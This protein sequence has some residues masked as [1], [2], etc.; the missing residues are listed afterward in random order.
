MNELLYYT[1]ADR[2]AASAELAKRRWL[3]YVPAALLL[4]LSVASFI[5]FRLHRNESG[6]P[7]TALLTMLGGAY[8]LFFQEVYLLPA[9]RYH[10]HVNY[11]LGNFLREAEGAIVSL[12]AEAKDN[13]GLDCHAMILNIGHDN[14]PN[15]E[16]LFYIDALKGLPEVTQGMRVRVLSNNRMIA[17]LEPAPKEN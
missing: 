3:V 6:W 4:L 1:Q 5:A 7:I 10:T 2:E 9:K 16:R 12:D 11:M 15:D 8:F 14:D 17:K 13:E